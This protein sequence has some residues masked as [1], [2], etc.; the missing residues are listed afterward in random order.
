MHTG[1]EDGFGGFEVPVVRCGNA[2]E[3]EVLFEHFGDSG[4]AGE[5]LKRRQEICGLLLVGSGAGAGFGGDSGELNIDVTKGAVV[6][7][8][9]GRLFKKGAVGV[10]EDHAHADHTGF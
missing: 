10:V 4:V 1:L 5:A 6:E 9:F 3:V 2:G 7:T 8:A